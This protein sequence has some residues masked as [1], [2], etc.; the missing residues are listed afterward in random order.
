VRFS[1]RQTMVIVICCLTCALAVTWI[2]KGLYFDP[3]HLSSSLVNI[4]PSKC[5][6]WK[7]AEINSQEIG[8]DVAY[9]SLLKRNGFGPGS[10]IWKWIH[11][12][13]PRPPVNEN[14]AH[15]QG[16]P[17]ISSILI[18]GAGPEGSP[19]GAWYIRTTNHLYRWGF[20]KGK[21][22]RQHQE[23]SALQEYDKAFDAVACWQQGVPVKSD[24]FLDGYWG[25]LSLFRD[26]KSRQML[27][28]FRD[29]CLVDPEII[30]KE[31][32]K[33]TMDENNWGRLWKTLKPVFPAPQ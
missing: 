20:N 28:T 11:T 21:F 14:A 27:L 9:E 10:V 7:N 31:G 1:S 17:I 30:N 15:W 33:I 24:T 3:P 16:E 4:P 25:F 32:D 8:W 26:G 6:E 22:E 13:G 12:D 5:E 19:G 2:V 18:E 23:L 29:L